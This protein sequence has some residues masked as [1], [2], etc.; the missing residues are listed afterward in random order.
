MKRLNIVVEGQTEQC[1]V[2]EVLSPYLMNKGVMSVT[3]I[4]IRT[5]KNGRGGFVNYQHLRNTVKGLLHNPTDD[6]LVVT[7]FVDFFRIPNNMPS[8]YEAMQHNDDS[9]KVEALQQ[10]LDVDIADKRFIPYIQM[11]EFEALLFS[12]NNGFECYWDN[13]LSTE[14]RNIIN[15]FDNPENI[16][17]SPEKA[18]SKRLLAINQK[19]DK[20]L[21]GNLIAIEVGINEMLAK[22]PRFSDWISRIISACSE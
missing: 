19:Y 15:E 11:H 12:N 3:A 7:S 5:S 14:T 2:K 21:E 9:H 18:P 20:V 13:E 1:F 16:N 6:N 22:C 10:A 4:L 17:S 8:Y